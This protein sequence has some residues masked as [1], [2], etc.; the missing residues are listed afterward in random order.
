MYFFICMI[1]VQDNNQRQ[2]YN[3]RLKSA[4]LHPIKPGQA[5]PRATHYCLLAVTSYHSAHSMTDKHS[6]R[7]A[8][9]QNAKITIK[10]LSIRKK[11]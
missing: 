10:I 2:R 4:A 9:K 7:H 3:N 8:E 6:R 11:M 5:L 1:V